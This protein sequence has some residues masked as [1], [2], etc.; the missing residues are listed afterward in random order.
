MSGELETDAS[1]YP[2]ATDIVGK[3]PVYSGEKILSTILSGGDR[4]AIMDELHQCLFSGPGVLIIKHLMDPELCKRA[5]EFM[6]KVTPGIESSTHKRTARF[7][8]KQAVQSPEDYAGY[9]SN[10]IL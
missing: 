2:L 1:L 10:P 6:Q 8:E 9:Y 5:H 7:G 3:I 4:E